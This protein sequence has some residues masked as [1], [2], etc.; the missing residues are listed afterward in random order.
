MSLPHAI[1]VKGPFPAPEPSLVYSSIF[2]LKTWREDNIL[3]FILFLPLSPQSSWAFLVKEYESVRLLK[4]Q[5]HIPAPCRP[6]AS[7]I[8][9]C[10]FLP[11]RRI[12]ASHKLS[13]YECQVQPHGTGAYCVPLQFL[14]RRA[15]SSESSWFV[16]RLSWC[17][18]RHSRGEVVGKFAQVAHQMQDVVYGLLRVCPGVGWSHAAWKWGKAAWATVNWRTVS[19][20]KHSELWPHWND[21]SESEVSCANTSKMGHGVRLLLW[22]T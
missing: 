18:S 16:P 6:V 5:E 2:G 14:S 11:M 15:Y 17:P 22:Y 20:L 10:H 4:P 12:S 13:C 19:C 1:F 21:D 9:S 7:Y 3:K 8:P